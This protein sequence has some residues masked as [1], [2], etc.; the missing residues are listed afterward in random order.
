MEGLKEYITHLVDNDFNL[1]IDLCEE[2]SVCSFRGAI[3]EDG[4][5]NEPDSDQ[6]LSK[7]ILQRRKQ[8][9]VEK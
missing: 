8:K 4:G 5:D 9:I 1:K 3:R 7:F 2:D 6:E